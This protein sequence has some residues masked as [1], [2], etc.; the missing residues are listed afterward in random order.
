MKKKHALYL[1]LILVTTS[2]FFPYNNLKGNRYERT[3]LKALLIVVDDYEVIYE[4]GVSGNNEIKNFIREIE[5]GA[6]ER[7]KNLG[8][9][10][11]FLHYLQKN[12]IVKL[13]KKVLRG[14]KATSKNIVTYINSAVRESKE[15]EIFLVY[16]SGH[17][18]MR[19]HNGNTFVYG[20]DGNTIKRS[21][22]NMLVNRSKARLNL[23]ITDNG[24]KYIPLN[25][26]LVSSRFMNDREKKEAYIN[27]LY[28]YRGMLHI[29]AAS[30]GEEAHPSFFTEALFDKTLMASPESTW[31]ENF[32]VAKEKTAAM[33]SR[34]GKEQTPK[35]YALPEY[36]TKANSG[37]IPVTVSRKVS[38]PMVR[39]VSSGNYHNEGDVWHYMKAKHDKSI[40]FCIMGDGYTQDDLTKGGPYEKE[41]KKLADY[42]FSKSPFREYREYFNVYIVFVRSRERGADD[43]PSYNTRDTALN[44]SYGISGIQRLLY[45]QNSQMANHY[46]SKT[47]C[48]ID[49]IIVS[50]NDTRYGGAGGYLST[51]SRTSQSAQIILHELGHTFGNLADEYVDEASK[52]LYPISGAKDCA[53]VD[54][55]SDP[56]RVKWAKFIGQKGFEGTGVFEGG[57][58][59]ATGVWRARQTCV[60]EGL[61]NDFCAAC[62][63]ALVKKIA[64]LTG[65]QYSFTDYVNRKNS[66]NTIADNT[67]EY[68]HD[69]PTGHNPE[70]SIGSIS[71]YNGRSHK[72]YF[73]VSNIQL[74]NMEGKAVSFMMGLSQNGNW[75]PDSFVRVNPQNIT[76]NPS[77][78][79]GPMRFI[80]EL[81]DLQ[82]GN[83]NEIYW[84]SFFIMDNNNTV[85]KRIDKPFYYRTN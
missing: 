70:A 47:G 28:N 5:N 41:C 20:A 3:T 67:N 6:R 9:L 14:K 24:S 43:S 29:S 23:L 37:Q 31:E 8:R 33:A 40:N 35:A 19:D 76:Y 84:A 12:N 77:Y 38:P 80:Y 32:R 39:S 65:M 22:L 7:T 52:H 83:I 61:G 10:N 81:A 26:P 13:E 82:K 51:S 74:T 59:R 66:M 53:N 71:I 17:G 16:F 75:V 79:E 15:N 46:A 78:W 63:E 68:T 69:M 2:L 27:L 85:L 36:I 49:S 72:F 1:L 42:I 44:S 4:D 56:K 54:F 11:N 55:T 50:V 18:G 21:R 30:E 34:I 58:Y 45:A 64:Q 73:D 57:Y 48:R 62:Q 60:M 25:K